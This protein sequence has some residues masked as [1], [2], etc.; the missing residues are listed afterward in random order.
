[1]RRITKPLSLILILS[2]SIS[3]KVP[4]FAAKINTTAN[5]GVVS[6]NESMFPIADGVDYGIR[7]E[8]QRIFMSS[9]E[10]S[11]SGFKTGVYLNEGAAFS[12]NRRNNPYFKATHEKSINNDPNLYRVSYQA[13]YNSNGEVRQ[14]IPFFG[15]LDDVKVEFSL[16]ETNMFRFYISGDGTNTYTAS[17]KLYYGGI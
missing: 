5:T 2:L 10:Y 1:M 15:P 13:I 8:N 6:S 3:M 4:V 17:G 16:N 7:N 9:Y 12:V 14:G 11:T